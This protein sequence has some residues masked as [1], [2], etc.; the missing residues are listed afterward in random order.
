MGDPSEPDPPS[1]PPINPFKLN[2]MK[3]KLQNLKD[4]V[5]IHKKKNF[6]SMVK[7]TWPSWA[8][9][10]QRSAPVP[11]E[12]FRNVPTLARED[13]CLPALVLWAP[14]LQ[15]P[16]YYENGRPACIF[17][18]GCY[19]CVESKGWRNLPRRGVAEKAVA[20]VWGKSYK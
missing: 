15:F 4:T 20:Y 12:E 13:F 2:W 19:D 8:T 3:E 11:T 9:A 14:E 6:P 18:R 17:H 16:Q 1:D 10:L 7:G 5:W